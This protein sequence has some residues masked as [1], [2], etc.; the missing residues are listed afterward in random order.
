MMSC[1]VNVKGTEIL[2]NEF[3]TEKQARE[4]IKAVM[5]IKGEESY[6]EKKTFKGGLDEEVSNNR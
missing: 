5:N 4:I 3:I 1:Q 6:R 2:L